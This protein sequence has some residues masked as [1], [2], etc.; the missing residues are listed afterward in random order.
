MK[1]NHAVCLS[2]LLMLWI[3]L[4]VFPLIDSLSAAECQLIRIFGEKGAAGNQIQIK[5]AEVTISRDTCVVWINWVQGSNMRIIF[6]E[7]AK[8]CRSATESSSGFTE[9][10]SFYTTSF[11]PR[12][13]TSSLTFVGKGKFRYNIEIPDVSRSSMGLPPGQIVAEGTLIVE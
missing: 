2:A 5:P 12:G 4:S 8:A 9:K 3:S 1:K 11:I 6:R 7:D 13:G 10:D